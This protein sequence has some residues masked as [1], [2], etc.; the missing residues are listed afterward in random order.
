MV[1]LH[2][3]RL[4]ITTDPAHGIARIVVSCDVD[5]TEYEVNAMNVLGLRYSLEC[6]LLDMDMLYP[7]TIVMFDRQSLPSV[8]GA[9]TRSEHVSFATSAPM[10]ALHQYVFGKDPLVGQLMLTNVESGAQVIGRSDVVAVD[11]AV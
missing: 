2:N 11:L 8:R 4:A 5:F 3:I 6:S 10:R 9:A 7:D 1:A